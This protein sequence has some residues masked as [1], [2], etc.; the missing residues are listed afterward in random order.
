MVNGSDTPNCVDM[1]AK[2]PIKCRCT[3]TKIKQIFSGPKGVLA[4]WPL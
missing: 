2:T 3:I 4:A 1:Q